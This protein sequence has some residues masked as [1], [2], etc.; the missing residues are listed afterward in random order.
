MNRLTALANKRKGFTLIE[1]MIVVAIIGILSAV[2]IPA[3]L[4]YVRR[5]KTAEAGE[6][7]RAMYIG[8]ATYYTE[9][10][11]ITRGVLSG[12]GTATSQVACVTG[13]ATELFTPTAQKQTADY[14]SQP[15]T[16]GALRFSVAEPAYFAY[17]IPNGGTAGCNNAAPV[18]GS[19]AG[20]YTFQA[21]GNLDGDAVFSTFEVAAGAN[22]E[23][24]L[25]R[26]PGIYMIN[27][28]E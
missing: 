4:G 13:A 3:L 25:V 15:A 1:L 28:I 14:M 7:L 21:R 5:S 2:A 6:N 24:E 17:S 12:T 19:V 9:E 27:E 11:M 16:Y 23:N 10:R 8:A 18:A 20:I 22:S 26:S